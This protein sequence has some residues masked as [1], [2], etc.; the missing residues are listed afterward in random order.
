MHTK[1]AFCGG[2]FEP[3]VV[4]SLIL[5]VVLQSNREV[6]FSVRL[7]LCSGRQLLG[8]QRKRGRL[9][10]GHPTF[11]S[12]PFFSTL[13]DKVTLVDDETGGRGERDSA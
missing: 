11:F 12:T 13:G 6:V 5:A 1:G 4:A 3:N 2:N 9:W 7:L 10:L 8:S